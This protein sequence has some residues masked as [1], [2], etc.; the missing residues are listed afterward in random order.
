MMR[1]WTTCA[2]AMLLFGCQSGEEPV[3]GAHRGIEPTTAYT[4]RLE[5]SK[6]PAELPTPVE[7]GPQRIVIGTKEEEPKRDLG[8]ELRSAVG[9]PID[10]VRD[11]VAPAPTTIRVSVTG[12]VRP[13]GMII[14]PSAHG[15]GL[16]EAA[17]QCIEQRVGRVALKPLDES[18]SQ[19]ASTII[20]INYEPERIVE[21]DPQTPEPR[22]TDVVQPLPKRPTLPPSGTRIDDP[23]RGWPEGGDVKHIEGPKPRKVTGPKPRPIEGYEVDENAQVWR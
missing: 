6:A 16:S 22:L 23:F 15:S 3:R 18:V 4:P 17:R 12:T 20:E 8:A 19:R 1:A 2:A 5:P 10:C 7:R 9:T 11:F 13:T 21:A 14:E